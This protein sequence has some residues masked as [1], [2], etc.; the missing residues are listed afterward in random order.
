MLEELFHLSLCSERFVFFF[1]FPT[2]SMDFSV[3]S[4]TFMYCFY[5]EIYSFM[6]LMGPLVVAQSLVYDKI[7]MRRNW[8]IFGAKSE[9]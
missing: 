2:Y 5:F 3:I 7:M 4:R 9:S 8:T 6:V 1:I